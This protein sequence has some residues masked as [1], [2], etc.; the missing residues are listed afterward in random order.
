MISFI[1]WARVSRQLLLGALNKVKRCTAR[2][3]CKRVKRHAAAP[4]YIHLRERELRWA[5]VPPWRHAV[6]MDRTEN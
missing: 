3:H 5:S 1:C 6:L 4:Y 2:K